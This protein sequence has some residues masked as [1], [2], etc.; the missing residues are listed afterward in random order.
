LTFFIRVWYI[1]I[2]RKRRKCIEGENI[3]TRADRIFEILSND[4][5]Q[6]VSEV[7]DK[8]ASLEKIDELNV[9]IIS[10]TARQDNRVRRE[11]KK[12]TGR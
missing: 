6:K 11:S 9:S 4:G 3:I 10:A 7:R 5:R 2:S 1:R 12:G 8:L